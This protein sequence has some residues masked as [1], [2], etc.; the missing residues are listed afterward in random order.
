MQHRTLGSQGLE[1]SAIGYGAMGLTMAYGP[2]DAEAGVAALR[3]AHDL[4]VTFF[5]TAEM[6]GW[7]TGSNEILVGKAV[8]DFRDDVVLATK[9]GVDMSV[10]PEQI[11]GALRVGRSRHEPLARLQDPMPGQFWVGLVVGQGRRAAICSYTR[12]PGRT[13]LP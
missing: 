1:V 12:S 4:G 11:G 3:R 2:T 8:R 9:F 6:Y 10:P 5:D 7:G 13:T